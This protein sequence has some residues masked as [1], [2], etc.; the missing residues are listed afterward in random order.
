LLRCS[1][2]IARRLS[3]L[4]P[5]LVRPLP[6]GVDGFFELVAGA[7]RYRASQLAGRETIPVS[8]R[9]LTDT[10]CLELQLVELSAVGNTLLRGALCGTPTFVHP[11][12]RELSQVAARL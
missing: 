10:E 4:Q 2:V 1:K 12:I 11:T 5:I 6:G 3:W 8:V 7:Q 9:E